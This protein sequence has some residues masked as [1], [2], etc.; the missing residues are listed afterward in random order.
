M[1]ETIAIAANFTIE[2][3]L[4]VFS[5]Y[6]DR[7]GLRGQT[8]IA[9]F[10]QIFQQLLD[11][12]SLFYRNESGVNVIFLRIEGLNRDDKSLDSL[13]S[14]VEELAR[15]LS[16]SEEFKVPVFVFFCPPSAEDGGNNSRSNRLEKL[17]TLL[18]DRTGGVPN[19]HFFDTKHLRSRYSLGDYDNPKGNEL[20]HVPYTDDLYAALAVETVR[21]I[22]AH[23][24][25]PHKVIVL[26]CDNTLWN[27][28]CGEDGTDGITFCDSRLALQKF[29]AEQSREGMLVC[30]CSK[31]NEP[32]VWDVFDRRSEMPLKREHLVSWRI[33]WEPKSSNL[34]SLADELQL[35]LDSF[36]FVDDDPA[37]CAEVRENCPEVFTF[38]LPQ[39]TRQIPGQLDHLWLFDRLKVTDEDRKRTEGYQREAAR[40]RVKQE[41]SDLASFLEGLGLVCEIQEIRDD[42]IP[43]VSQLSLRTNQFNST[44]VR[45]SEAEVRKIVSDAKKQ[46][47]TVNVKDRFGDY[48]LVGAVSFE[49]TGRAFC[50]D[51][52]M[53]SC[54]AL[55]RGVEHRILREIGSRAIDQG[56]EF[57]D[58][59]FRQTEKNIP[60]RKFLEE[61]DGAPKQQ[62]NGSIIFRIP[63]TAAVAV[64]PS[65]NAVPDAES[66][67]DLAQPAVREERYIGAGHEVYIE[68]ASTLSQGIS[69]LRGKGA[70]SV[71]RQS[72]SANY[73]PASSETELKLLSIWEGL[74]KQLGIGIL[75]NFFELGGDSLLGVNLF[76]EIEETFGSALPLSVL[77]ESPTIAKLAERIDGSTT[78]SNWKYLV[79]IQEGGR[80][81]PLFCMHAAG[82][83][84]LFYRDLAK[85]LGSD[86]PVYGLQA[87]GVA[88]KTE[89]A[90]DRVEDMAAEYL[91]EIRSF[92]P[93]GPYRLCGSS[94]GGLVAF[95]VARQ[96]TQIGEEVELLALFDTYAPGY[97]KKTTE[98]GVPGRLS[99]VVGRI[100]SLNGQL[101]EID[102]IRG[103]AAF[104]AGRIN[105]LKMRLKRKALWK[106]NEFAIQYSK[107]TGKDLPM[108]LQRNHKAIQIA[109]DTY[110]P[111]AYN[112]GIIL[113][114]A[115]EQPSG[116]L[117]DQ[118]LGWKKY[119]RS[120][121]PVIEVKGTHGALTVY[122][123]AEDLA[124][125][126][127][128]FLGH[129]V[130]ASSQVTELAFTN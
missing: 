106:K 15:A 65:S 103:R 86:Q 125:K 50:V 74:L 4:P 89:T 94:F 16:H 81:P 124:E 43:R 34:R 73:V 32:D 114:R 37:V 51:S 5:S 90:H 67:N 118:Y 75:D 48:G 13:E 41:S 113:F 64:T 129:T 93:D 66:K 88:D 49:S 111:S 104:L 46:I 1:R 121:I 109:L 78:H 38:M 76:V 39:D 3:I 14:N 45:R 115:M 42:Q 28:V 105:K 128:P 69:A 70:R 99:T 11:Q 23:I 91:E 54:R 130:N 21:K 58:I 62:V 7:L 71:H 24:R 25:N 107:A 18:I 8:E 30:L 68:I 127:K 57:V 120:E 112:G 72:L 83:N 92:Q 108:D 119:V 60:I 36:I 35:G 59:E 126:F 101:H 29:A 12:S 80:V 6:L 117:F 116:V 100:K 98:G 10:D 33:N 52:F 96:L 95:E 40:K 27:G 110:D 47:W 123:F 63:A 61:I 53:L 17:E 102:T 84:V 2:P 79:P 22:D 122:P 9:P 44:T 20:A 97:L 85:E 19:I 87:R 82:G 55:G 56:I 26:D 31:N 77:I